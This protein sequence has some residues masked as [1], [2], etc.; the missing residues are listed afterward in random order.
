[1]PV[2]VIVVTG[3]LGSGKTT[4]LNHVLHNRAGVRVGVLVND[5][6]AINVDAMSL[7]AHVDTMMALGNGCLCCAIDTE[8]MADTLQRLAEADIDVIIVEASGLAEPQS[9]VRLVLANAGERLV[10]GG[11]LEVVD[12]SAFPETSRRHPEL[13]R[14]LG[15]ADLVVLN[16][17]D[18]VEET[19][20]RE[21]LATIGDA[22][23]D[24]PVLE[25]AH[26]ALDPRLLFD[27]AE[28]AGDVPRQLSFDEID[29]PGEHGVHEQ[30]VHAGYRACTFEADGPL[31]PVRLQQ[32]LRRR[33]PNLFRIKGYVHFDVPGHEQPFALHTVG[34][35]LRLHRVPAETGGSWSTRLVLI[36]EALDEQA[37][38][39]GLRDCLAK[40]ESS[41]R[42][43]LELL[44]YEH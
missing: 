26:G 2:P 17:T 23:G 1:M 43:L 15:L 12:A 20:R 38:L 14:H 37:L 41:E 33:P 4:L 31:D 9:V 10:Y 35:H 39:H 24:V 22:G 27:P 40:G 42:D 21:V 36:G 18:L 3:F 29:T 32:W 6:G 44:R 5:F 34:R 8:D 30:H 13:L 11:L 28:V 16:K 19:V 7:S 25:T